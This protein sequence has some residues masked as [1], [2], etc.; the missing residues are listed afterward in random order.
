MT[1]EIRP[2]RIPP[3]PM[4]DLL[5]NSPSM[6]TGQHLMGQCYTL[7]SHVSLAEARDL[8]KLV[9]SGIPLSLLTVL[10]NS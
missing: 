2:H 3:S 1:V 7:S 4:Q 5:S 9:R 8:S 10:N 6:N